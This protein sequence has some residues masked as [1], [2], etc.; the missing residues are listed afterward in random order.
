MP[1]E[2]YTEKLQIDTTSSF[3]FGIVSGTLGGRVGSLAV[4]QL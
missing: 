2:P 4:G 1:I 3:D